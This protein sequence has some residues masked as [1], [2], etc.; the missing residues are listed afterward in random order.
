MAITQQTVTEYTWLLSLED[1]VI[2]VSTD[3]KIHTKDVDSL[4]RA[5]AADSSQVDITIDAYKN[6]AI[7]WNE[8]Y[9]E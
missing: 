3:Q 2:L 9:D 5:M 6:V 8:R 7:M 1:L 4:K